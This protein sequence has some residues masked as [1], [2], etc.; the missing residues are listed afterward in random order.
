M[1]KDQQN[2]KTRITNQFHNTEG[3]VYE[4]RCDGIA[5]VISMVDL[6]TEWKATAIAKVPPD[7]V[8]ATG[9]GRNGAQAFSALREA[10]CA[11]REGA[12]FPRLDWEA[13]QQ[14]LSTVRAI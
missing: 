10:W 9:A 13:I 14:A 2:P 3:M 5:V 7:R 1:R 8:A 11:Q 4:L 12:P 6:E